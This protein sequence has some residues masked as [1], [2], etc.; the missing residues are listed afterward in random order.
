MPALGLRG[1]VGCRVD[2]QLEGQRQALARRG[3][4]G[5]GGQGAAGGVAA[6]AEP[7]RVRAERGTR[8]RRPSG[9][10][11]ARPRTPRGRGARARAGSPP[12]APGR[13]SARRGTGRPGRGCRGRRTPS[14]RR[15]SRRAAGSA[16]SR[17]SGRRAGP[18]RSPTGRSRTAPIG[19]SPPAITVCRSSARRPSRHRQGRDLRLAHGLLQPQ[20]ELGVGGEGL[21]VDGHPSPGERALD[22]LGQAERGLERERLGAQLRGGEEGRRGGHGHN[23]A[24]WVELVP[25]RVPP[26]ACRTSSQPTRARATLNPMVQLA[27]VDPS[28]DGDTPADEPFD[29]EPP[30]Q[31]DEAAL[32]AVAAYDDRFLDRELSWL[33]FNQRVLELAEDDEPAAARA[34]A[35]L[36]DLRQQPRR[37]LHGARGRPEAPDRG[38][39]GRARRLRPDAARGARADLGR[40]PRAD[41]A[42]RRACSARSW[43][44]R[45]PRRASTWSAGTSSTARSSGSASGSSRSGSSRC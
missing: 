11:R 43:C 44:R 32:A 6:D 31:P 38:R 35:V 17:A 45:C 12:T 3:D 7:G 20:H 36:G 1:H 23:L 19:W 14:R 18:R 15:G 34:G 28:R 22:P 40:H 10:P 5:G 42:P 2:Q 29:V 16:P 30:Y 9:T 33:R 21:P 4:R 37:V 8:A 24:T 26:V 27:S 39:P 13:R 25:S 41:G